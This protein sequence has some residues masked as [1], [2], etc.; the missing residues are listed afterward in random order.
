MHALVV[1]AG[2]IGQHIAL[3]LAEA[4]HTVSLASRRGAGPSAEVLAQAAR[5]DA[6]SRVTAVVVD[7]ADADALAQAAAGASVI[8]NAVNPPYTTWSTAWPPMA[9]AF[10]GAAEASGAGLVTIGNLYG[11]GRVD[12]PMAESTPVAPNGV[13]GE[14]RA[15]MWRD[16]LAAHTALR[17]RAVELR[18]S[19]YFGPGA[20]AGV[21]FLNEYVVKPAAS[22]R[23]ARPPV[24]DADAPHSWTYLPDIAALAVAVA[25]ADQAGPDWGR[26]W[27]VPTSEPR[28]QR[29]VARDAAAAAGGADAVVRPLPR[30][31]MALARVV[32]LVRELD[33]TR[34]QF[35]RPFVLDSTAAQERFGLRP[36][37]WTDALRATV[38]PAGAR[39]FS[40]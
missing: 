27:H 13:K 36:T 12:A 18:A 37:E 14:V 16:A 25:E 33:E 34:H 21:S 40:G 32:P 29:E 35:E 30:W 22:G 15:G 8:V 17:V 6:A 38:D 9:A 28:S 4:G 31:V 24:G 39:R 20:G 7:A 26:V 19:D 5:S 10:L 1:G 11:Y 2:G 3:Q 23:V